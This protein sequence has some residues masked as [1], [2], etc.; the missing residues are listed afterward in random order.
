MD[1]VFQISDDITVFRDGKHIATVPAAEATRTKLITMM[2]GRELTELF[3]KLEALIGEVVLSVRNLSRNGHVRNVSFDL[4]R[5]E[6]L[7]L[8]GLMGSGRTE[9]IETIF[10]VEKA[11]SGEI[12]INGKK[13][14]INLH[15]MRFS[16][17]W[18]CSPK[19][20]S[21]PGS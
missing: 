2:V 20:A 11:D 14:Q 4:R 6:I 5:G 21:S 15:R 1:E 16:M 7:G 13:V 9:T 18:P 19:I 12:F 17:A 10:G 3:P 8:A